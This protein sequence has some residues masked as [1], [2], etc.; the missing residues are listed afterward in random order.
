MTYFSFIPRVAGYKKG[1][2]WCIPNARKKGLNL[3]KLEEN[4]IDAVGVSDLRDDGDL[5]RLKASLDD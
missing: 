5:P 4:L 2:E 3:P 1:G